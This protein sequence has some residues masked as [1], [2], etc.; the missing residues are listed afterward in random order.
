MDC[1]RRSESNEYANQANGNQ[2]RKQGL[3]WRHLN[4]S[5]FAQ[6]AFRPCM[7]AIG[8]HMAPEAGTY[9]HNIL[10]AAHIE[11]SSSHIFVII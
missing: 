8:R 11:V 1:A 7:G 3:G 5:F 2:P 4:F 6:R 9:I 10:M